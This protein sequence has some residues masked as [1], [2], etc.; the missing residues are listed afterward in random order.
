MTKERTHLNIRKKVIQKISVNPRYY[1]KVKKGRERK[2][3]NMGSPQ[4]G[5][6]GK[7]DSAEVV[8]EGYIQRQDGEAML[9]RDGSC[10]AL[11]F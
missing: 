7:E 10:N 9:G 2:D 5:G 8:G 4:G 3:E 11:R 6:R 1:A